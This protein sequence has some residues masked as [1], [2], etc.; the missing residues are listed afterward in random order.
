M[1]RGVNVT[2][3]SSIWGWLSKIQKLLMIL[4][5]IGIVLL[6]AVIVILRYVI[7][8]DIQG[9]EELLLLPAFYLY[10]MGAS[11]ASYENSHISADMSNDF[12]KNQ[13]VRF[14]VNLLALTI[15]FVSSVFFFVW[16]FN[17]FYWSYTAKGATA[18]WGIPLFVVY[19]SVLVSFVLIVLYNLV[20]LVNRVRDWKKEWVK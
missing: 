8:E 12:I 16:S 2:I 20:H 6:L 14:I 7:K 3:L 19:S 9:I 17:Q 10:F 4:S 1:E 15:T 5:S 18:I 13:R 11:Y